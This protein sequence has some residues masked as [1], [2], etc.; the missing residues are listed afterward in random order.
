[1]LWLLCAS[2]LMS[3]TFGRRLTFALAKVKRQR[4]GRSQNPGDSLD[5]LHEKGVI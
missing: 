3:L 5:Y 2:M 1:M 4:R